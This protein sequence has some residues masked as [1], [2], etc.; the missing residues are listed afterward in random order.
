MTEKATVLMVADRYFPKVDGVL[1]F[2]EEFMK[3]AQDSFELRVLVPKMKG[4]SSKFKKI[5]TAYLEVSEKW[6]L[7]GYPSIK[8]SSK[9]RTAIKKA[10]KAADIVFVQEIAPTG[11]YAAKYA[12]RFK[13][14]S[15][16]Y[17][18][19]T[20]WDFIIQYFSLSPLLAGIVKRFFVRVFN[21]FSL[22]LL[23]YPDL[24]R[25]MREAGVKSPCKI[26]R[27]GVDIQRFSPAKD[28]SAAKKAIKL[29]PTKTVVGYV[30]RVSTEKNIPVLLSAFRKLHDPEKYHLLIVGDGSP[31]IIAKCKKLRN[32]TVTGF[33]E[34]VEKYVKAMD[35]FVMPSR[36]ETTSLATLEAMASGVAVISS[37]VGFMQ[38]YIR[39]DQNGMFFPKNNPATLALKI[40]KLRKDEE[41]RETLANNGR[42]MVAYSFS[43]ERSINRVIRLLMDVF[44][45]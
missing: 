28:K 34:N 3:R 38:T 24:E 17:I 27:L 6:K 5:P 16:L 9:N 39:K 18:H 43:W 45:K 25:E 29:D 14:K 2:M 7:A 8:F 41:S 13:K 33:V 23:P 32:C 44:H 35:I 1:I 26:A 30:G 22:L 19:N 36:T 37:R 40:E 4:K 11:Y 10:V 42:R 21:K 12:K 20:H 31:E 15:V